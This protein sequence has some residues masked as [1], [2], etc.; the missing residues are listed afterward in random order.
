MTFPVGK[1]RVNLIDLWTR[2]TDDIP[3]ITDDKHYI[4][5][6]NLLTCP[7]KYN[8]KSVILYKNITFLIEPF[9]I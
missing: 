4:C 2:K 8:R 7:L 3:R 1:L 6:Q 9:Q 5:S